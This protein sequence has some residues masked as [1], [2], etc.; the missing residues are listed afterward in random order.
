MAFRTWLIQFDLELVLDLYGTTETT[1]VKDDDNRFQ[2]KNKS[3]V[4]SL[5]YQPGLFNGDGSRST[6]MVF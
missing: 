4:N 6:F 2:F 3:I 5:E 1:Y